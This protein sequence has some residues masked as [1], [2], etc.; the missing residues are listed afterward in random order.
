MIEVLAE[1]DRVSSELE[2]VS[3]ELEDVSVELTR[4]PREVRVSRPDPHGL[5]SQLHTITDGDAWSDRARESAPDRVGSTDSV[6]R[7]GFGRVACASTWHGGSVTPGEGAARR[8]G[9][10]SASSCTNSLRRWS[11]SRG[12]CRTFSC[13]VARVGH[14]CRMR[15]RG[16][17][18]I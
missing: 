2:R 11:N 13:R 5:P 9:G 15:R 4:V 17:S 8:G 3:A 6:A 12:M 16:R 1:L 18:T 10:N 7:E 14:A